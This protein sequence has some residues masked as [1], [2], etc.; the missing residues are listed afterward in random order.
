MAG[1]AMCRLAAVAAREFGLEL[2]NGGTVA[3]ENNFELT[4]SINGADCRFFVPLRLLQPLARDFFSLVKDYPVPE[5]LV[6]ATLEAVLAPW[7]SRLEKAAG[8]DIVLRGVTG[9]PSGAASQAPLVLSLPALAEYGSVGIAPA[10]E[11][12]L[13][14][15]PPVA[16]TTGNELVL[17]LPIVVAEIG[18]TFDEL[19]QLNAGDVVLLAGMTAQNASQVRLAISPRRVII[20]EIDGQKLT[21]ARVG[22]AMS[23]ND[24]ASDA[25]KPSADGSST[26]VPAAALEELPLRLVFDLGELELSLAE[27]RTMVPGQVIDLARQP[28][29]AVRVSINGRRIGAGEIVEIEGR[30]GVRITELT[31]R[32]ERPA[33]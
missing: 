18:V 22:K 25:D 19:R 5:S 14:K 17:R 23:A 24:A 6:A 10:P 11:L 13:P 9:A 32:N 12:S 8:I 30:L 15:V 20:A 16:W 27:L 7:I 2:A 31:G 4:V 29:N 3:E 1:N 26:V 28:G 21:V 33:S